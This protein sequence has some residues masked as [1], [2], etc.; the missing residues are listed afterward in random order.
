MGIAM[1]NPPQLSPEEQKVY[2]LIKQKTVTSGGI[3]QTLLRRQSELKGID[4]R[5]ITEIV[6]KL[7]KLKIVERIVVKSN[8]KRTYVLVAKEALTGNGTE[9]NVLSLAPQDLIDVR[10]ILLD[11][12][13]IRCRYLY[14]CSIGHA[15]DPLRCPLMAYF[16]LEKA[17]LISKS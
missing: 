15:H 8:G 2:N 16:M 5:K 17:G 10:S 13:C 11:I 7:I 14:S 12:P 6:R 3:R 1:S 9:R 4:P